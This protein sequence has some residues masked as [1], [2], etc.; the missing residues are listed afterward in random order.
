[1]DHIAQ[2]TEPFVVRRRNGEAWRLPGAAD[3]AANLKSCP[4]RFVLGDDLVSTCTALGFS[5][6]DELAGCLDL[7][8]IPAEHLWV[9][10]NEEARRAEL[11]RVIPECTEGE[12]N[13]TL[14]A[15]V[16]IQ[17]HAGGRAAR[18]RTFWLPR[19]QTPDALMAPIE[20]IV[21]LD[22]TL[23]S[24]PAEQLFEGQ[25][26]RLTDSKNPQLDNVLRCARFQFDPAW[27]RYYQ[28]VLPDDERRAQLV[29][30]SMASVAFDLPML[31]ALF[32]LQSIRAELI[33][34]PVSTV[35]INSK[36]GRLGR[37]PLLEHIQVSA[38]VFM[39]V[40]RQQPPGAVTMRSG[41]RF[42]H[43]R[44]HI[45]RRR[46]T[47]YWRGPHWRGHMRLGSVRTRTVNLNLS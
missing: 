43:V 27:L 41:P 18:L 11:A 13:E 40:S 47:V 32:L 10:W 39:Q 12:V 26:T 19:S 38:P 31:L 6:G 2:S 15:G 35:R 36:R 22:G 44:G 25:M 9:E 17:A 14:R 46:N 29:Q 7:L 1:M 8:H 20:T 5:E 24:A 28:H 23:H 42:H 34:S 3:F 33:E 21:S 45:V 37:A 4:L 16:L 30:T